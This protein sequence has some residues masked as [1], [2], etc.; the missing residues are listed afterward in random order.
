MTFKTLFKKEMKSITRFPIFELM[1][2]LSI[3]TF[4]NFY[5]IHVIEPLKSG[6][7]LEEYLIEEVNVSDTLLTSSASQIK[8]NFTT[9]IMGFIVI[10]VMIASSVAGEYEK[11]VLLSMIS[12]PV[13]RRDI[14][15]SKFTSVFIF[16]YLMLLFSGMV[17]MGFAY[18]RY[19]MVPPPMLLLAYLGS[20]FII[21]L[22]FCAV[23]MLI[24]VLS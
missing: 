5:L 9:N 12:Y 24:S 4:I 3:L 17:G 22:T 13:R 10:S 2:A 15:L 21:T 23:S 6:W 19:Y 11:G 7:G 8:F 16:V 14:L 20:L 1:L 18:G